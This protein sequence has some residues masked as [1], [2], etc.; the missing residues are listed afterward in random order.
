MTEEIQKLEQREQFLDEEIERV[1]RE[2]QE[3]IA[4]NN[5]LEEQK[6]AT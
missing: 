2:V 3:M 4:R 6:E 1:Q 5:E